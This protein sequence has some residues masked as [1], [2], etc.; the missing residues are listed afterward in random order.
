VDGVPTVLFLDGQG[1]EIPEARITGF[2]T[3]KEFLAIVSSPKVQATLQ[4]KA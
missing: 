2:L 4:K 3:P 1:V